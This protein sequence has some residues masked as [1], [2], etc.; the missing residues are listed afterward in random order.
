MIRTFLLASALTLTGVMPMQANHHHHGGGG[1]HHHGGGGHHHGGHWH[2]NN[3]RWYRNREAAWGLAGLATGAIIS[4]AIANS[5]AQDS[6]TIV[7]PETNR[8]LDYD[9][10]QSSPQLEDVNFTYTVDGVRVNAQANCVQG[11][12][13]GNP[14]E[15]AADAHTLNAVCHTAS[16]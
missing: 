5:R 10:D 3:W 1:H 14:P 15:S 12:I 6:P 16:N 7:V 4:S 2:H 8:M 13:N 9:L 11:L